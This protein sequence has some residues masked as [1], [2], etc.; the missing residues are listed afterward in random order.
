MGSKGEKGMSNVKR[1]VP[2]DE[3]RKQV[4]RYATSNLGISSLD[5]LPLR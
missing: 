1:Q 5:S 2:N 3:V 4:R